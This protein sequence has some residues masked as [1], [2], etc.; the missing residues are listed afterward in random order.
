METLIENYVFP[1]FFYVKGL[2][3]TDTDQATV[4]P[5]DGNIVQI[6][7]FSKVISL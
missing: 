5:S 4:L 6:K 3:V 1:L 7:S 2:Q